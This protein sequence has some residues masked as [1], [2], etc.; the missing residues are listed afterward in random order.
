MAR[1]IPIVVTLFVAAASAAA[2]QSARPAPV[3]PVDPLASIPKLAPLAVRA[4]SELAA[5]VERFATDQTSLNR[6]YD[7][8]DSPAQRKR[9]REFYTGWRTRLAELEFDK[10]GQEGKLDYVLLDN[11]LVHQLALLDRR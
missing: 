8:P 9:M 6:R 2:A 1:S 11:Y 7:A 5:V 4:G 3:K 10:L